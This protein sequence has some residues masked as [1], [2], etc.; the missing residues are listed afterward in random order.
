[1]H[2]S[3]TLRAFWCLV[4][5]DLVSEFRLR[6]SWPGMI[7]MGLVF[8]FL[9][10]MQVDVGEQERQ[11]VVSG[12]FWLVVF[13][14][15]TLTVE[16]SLASE[17]EEGCWTSLLM[18]PIPPATVFFAK[19]TGTVLALVLLE[20]VLVPAFIVFSNIPLLERPLSFVMLAML[21]NIGYASVGVV[22]STLTAQLSHRTSLLPLLLLPV[23]TPAILS[24][25]AA[26]RL[27]VT[28]ELTD[29]CWRWLQL[30]GCFAVVFTTLGAIV[31]EFVIEE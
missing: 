18:Y 2:A 13:F 9:L 21:A 17:R 20:C 23:M 3:H 19:A 29:D 24:A 10:E 25:A 8:V 26:T 6:R 7:L 11:Q 22:I 5:K 31:F 1:M 14:A 28:G 27:L 16:R 4:V 15:G 12:L 30:L